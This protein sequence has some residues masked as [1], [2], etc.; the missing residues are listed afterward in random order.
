M[1]V[2]SSK[3]QWFLHTFPEANSGEIHISGV[4]LP[5]YGLI[6]SNKKNVGK[7]IFI[8]FP[9][10]Y[11]SQLFSVMK[12]SHINNLAVSFKIWKQKNPLKMVVFPLHL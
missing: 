4:H 9:H 7:W 12:A 8:P 6:K 2:K 10:Q 5:S 11:P 3:I 1:M